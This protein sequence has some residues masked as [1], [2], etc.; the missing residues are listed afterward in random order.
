MTIK[1]NN[2]RYHSIIEY[3]YS[4][5]KDGQDPVKDIRQTREMLTMV[6]HYTKGIPLPEHSPNSKSMRGTKPREKG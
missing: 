6:V 5:R 1:D 3:R 2:N 4:N